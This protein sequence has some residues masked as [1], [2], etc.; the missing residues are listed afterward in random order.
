M[1][2]SVAVEG[3]V[4]CPGV[5]AGEWV[6]GRD[7]GDGRGGLREVGGR[8]VGLQRGGCEGTR[9]AGAQ[10]G[11]D[12]GI[13]ELQGE[14]VVRQSEQS[15][16]PGHRR[17][18]RGG[19]QHADGGGDRGVDGQGRPGSVDRVELRREG[20]IDGGELGELVRRQQAAGQRRRGDG[21]DEGDRRLGAGVGGDDDDAR[22][23]E[24]DGR[25][26]HLHGIDARGAAGQGGIG[27]RCGEGGGALGAGGGGIHRS[28]RHLLEGH[29]CRVSAEPALECRVVGERVATEA[30]GDGGRH[31]A[32]G[33]RGEGVTTDRVSPDRRMPFAAALR[34]A[35]PAWWTPRAT[36]WRRRPPPRPGARRR[37]PRRTPRGSPG[38]GACG[39]AAAR[40][41]PKAEKSRSYERRCHEGAGLASRRV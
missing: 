39:G 29:S 10:L 38:A 6:G 32:R 23:R 21:D 37:G 4:G 24:T 40:V 35:S 20:A 30:Q 17:G 11:G 16:E 15:L 31:G 2:S 28:G 26:A 3:Y 14:A 33:S 12:V 7:G 13:A 9:E 36:G 34:T 25:R 22:R 8:H 27:R 19:A 18:G 41:S 1:S 5:D